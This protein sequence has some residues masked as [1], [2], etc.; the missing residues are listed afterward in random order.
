[1]R[2]TGMDYAKLSAVQTAV[3]SAIYAQGRWP[4]IDQS[5]TLDTFHLCNNANILEFGARAAIPGFPKPSRNPCQRRDCLVFNRRARLKIGQIK[6][7]LLIAAIRTNSIFCDAQGRCDKNSEVCGDHRED[8]SV[9]V[10]DLCASEHM[11]GTTAFMLCRD[12]V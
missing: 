11:H 6:S 4:P 2:D 5:K 12:D 1:M 7:Q 8:G 9:K 10:S 3:L